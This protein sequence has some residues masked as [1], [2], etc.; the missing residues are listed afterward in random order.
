[1]GTKGKRTMHKR[2]SAC[3]VLLG[4]G[5]RPLVVHVGLL[6]DARHDDRHL[7]KATTTKEIKS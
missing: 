6:P 5:S 3:L 2:S 7:I 4:R 1:M